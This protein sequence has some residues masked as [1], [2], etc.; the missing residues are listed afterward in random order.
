[1]KVMKYTICTATSI[2]QLSSS[3]TK[4]LSEGWQLHGPFSM[5]YTGVIIN[6]YQAMVWYEDRMGG[7]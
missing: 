7:L 2:E 4:K 3:V 5:L 6:Y 1:M